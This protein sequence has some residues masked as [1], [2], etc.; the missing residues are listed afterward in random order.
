MSE[1][2][3]VRLLEQLAREHQLLRDKVVELTRFAEAAVARA[4]IAEK[5]VGN[6]QAELVDAQA[7][8]DAILSSRT[9][10]LVAPLRRVY[11]RIRRGRA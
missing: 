8:V 2:E 5:H 10:R 3:R 1:A 9:M 4:V 6:L 7:H 11:G